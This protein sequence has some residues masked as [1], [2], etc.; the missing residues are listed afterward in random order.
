M[1]AEIE[2]QRHRA[3]WKVLSAVCVF[4]FPAPLESALEDVVFTTGSPI[5]DTR[6]QPVRLRPL[7]FN[8]IFSPS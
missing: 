6:G 7:T 3:L 2:I 4:I 5:L 8:L 1:P